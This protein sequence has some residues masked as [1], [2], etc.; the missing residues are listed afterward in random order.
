M[1]FPRQHPA[2]EKNTGF[3]LKKIGEASFKAFAA[4]T[5]EHGLHP[6]HFGLLQMLAAEGAISQQELGARLGIDP[7]S[8]VARMDVLEKRGLIERRRSPEDRRAY[9]IA[10]TA[11]GRE[12]VA[13]LRRAAAAH[14]RRF[15]RA[16]SPEERDQLNALL[17]K[18]AATVDEDAASSH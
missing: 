4:R 14:S 10:L 1:T 7:S 8:M 6:M 18:V 13:T 12:V 3:M 11:E 5:A 16:L 17:A 9:E 2:L 15:F